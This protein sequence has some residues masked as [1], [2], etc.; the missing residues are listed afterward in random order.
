MLFPQNTII[1]ELRSLLNTILDE[2]E[3]LIEKTKDW[4]QDDFIN[5]LQRIHAATKY[6]LDIIKPNMP[7]SHEWRTPFCA[8]IGYG[9]MLQEDAEDL[10]RDDLVPNLQK[11][12][13]TG[14]QLL[15]M[16]NDLIDCSKIKEG[17]MDLYIESVELES[18]LNEIVSV[19]QPI[20]AKKGNILEVKSS[21]VL[22]EIRTDLSK[23]RQILLNILKNAAIF[24]EHG[25]ICL[26]VEPR[27]QAGSEWLVFSVIDNGIGMT[28]EQQKRL[29]CLFT[30]CD[31]H[32]DFGL[33][34]TKHFAEMMGGTI[35]V[36][37][38]LQNG[39][40]FTLSLPK[41]YQS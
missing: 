41:K 6:L 28:D 13:T 10:G 16:I 31:S 15:G 37:S 38:E 40:T 2:S 26:S 30:T 24:T 9:E 17:Q 34:L 20:L 25:T 39:S 27:I 5:G 33:I 29:F 1:N 32:K 12:H 3:I 36:K 4:Q 22:G 35:E 18:F 8:I 11:I 14:K 21:K 7:V 19:I 23:L